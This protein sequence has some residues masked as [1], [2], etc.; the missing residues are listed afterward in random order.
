MSEITLNDIIAL[1]DDGEVEAAL[2]QLDALIAEHN[3]VA[4]FHAIRAFFLLDLGRVADAERA[5]ELAHALDDEDPVP[6]LTLARV[7]LARGEPNEAI[8]WAR[9]AMERAP[10]MLEALVVEARARAMLGQWEDVIA[11]ADYVLGADP[12]NAE[13]AFLRIAAIESRDRGRGRLNEAEWDDLAARFPH[14]ATA[15]TGRGWA[16][17]QRGRAKGAEAEFRDALALDPSDPWAKQGLVV[18]LKARYPGYTLLLRFF[19]WLQSF[20]P[21]T[22]TII[23]IGGVLGARTL[24]RAAKNDPDL[25]PFILPVI[26]LYFAFVFVSWLADPLLDLTLMARAE[27]RRLLSD[28]DKRGALAVGRTLGVAILLSLAGLAVESLRLFLLPGLAIG[29]TSLTVAAAYQCAP[30]KERTGLLIASRAFAGLGL[31]AIVAGPQ[32][33]A[34]LVLLVFVGVAI[35]TWVSRPLIRRSHGG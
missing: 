9:A 25:A 14:V 32:L 13:A 4:A 30:G 26:V 34:G 6:T 29:F 23:L 15:R 10:E 20:E 21:R 5:A 17:L 24:S 31:A 11:R 1:A 22:Q 18:A 3:D 35:G 27:G 7:A 8:T 28:D 16:L 19:Y 2:A 33:G 12:H